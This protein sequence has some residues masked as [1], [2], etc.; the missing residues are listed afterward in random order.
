MRKALRILAVIAILAVFLSPFWILTTISFKPTFDTSSYW[1]FPKTP[2]LS[3]FK[4]AITGSGILGAIGRT[5]LITVCTVC[6]VIVVS[7]FTAYPLARRRTRFNKLIQVFILGVMMVPPLSI[8]VPLYSVVVSMKGVNHLWS[9]ILVL[10][11][12]QLPQGTFLY[13]NFIRSIPEALDEAASIDGC[14][15]FRTFFLVILPQLKPVTASVAILSFVNCWN[16]FQ[17]SRYFLQATRVNT[18]TLTI[19]QYFSQTYINLSTAAAC[20]MIGIIPVI[21]VYLILQKYFIQ[22]MIDSAIK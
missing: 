14:G 4:E 5:L 11:T 20:A 22:G 15:P 12:F 10:L 19:S 1:I 18:I 6:L 8:L 17:F 7:A 21:I 9:V 3:N 2:T 16:D 13:L